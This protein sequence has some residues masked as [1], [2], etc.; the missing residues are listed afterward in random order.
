MDKN[1]YI[2]IYCGTVTKDGQDGDIISQNDSQQSPLILAVDASVNESKYVKCAIRTEKGYKSTRTAISFVGLTQEKWKISKDDG[3]ANEEE[4]K[5]K[6]DF[7]K[8]LV[9]TDEVTD[10][11]V[12]FW[13]EA[14]SSNDE[15]PKKDTTV[16]IKVDSYIVV[17]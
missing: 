3:F 8:Q 16:S 5:T 6:G 11:N 4:A 15:K 13:V 2:N 7:Q 9:L 17:E 1:E 14:S 12:V 10:K